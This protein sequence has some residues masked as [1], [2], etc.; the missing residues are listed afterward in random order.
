MKHSNNYLYYMISHFMYTKT[1]VSATPMRTPIST[2]CD[3]VSGSS[4]N[5]PTL[6]IIVML[7]TFLPLTVSLVA[8]VLVQCVLILRMRK[9][10]RATKQNTP[11]DIYNE[12]KINDS[13]RSTSC[14]AMSMSQNDAY[15]LRS[16][17]V[18]KRKIEYENIQI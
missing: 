13:S 16:V 3:T 8:V 4:N 7:G 9:S 17:A 12:V 11:T 2:S 6:L 18:G 5:S 15:A 14:D 1:V 10:N